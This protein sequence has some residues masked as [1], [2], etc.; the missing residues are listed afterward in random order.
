MLCDIRLLLWLRARH[1]RTALVRL[2]HFG[3]TDLVEDRSPG[4]RAY[5]LYLAAIAAVWAALMWAA[6]LDATAAAFAAVGPA[7]SA[8]ALALGLLAPVAV[9]AWAAV[10]ALRTSPVKLAHAD[11][12]FVAAGPLGM[13]A[14]AGMGCASSMLAG[15]AAGALAGCVLDVGLESGLGAFAPPVAC[16]LAAALLVA[17]AVGGAWLLGAAR[18]AC[19]R[20]IRRRGTVALALA[21]VAAVL[22]VAALAL[23]VPPAAFAPGAPG[24]AVACAAGIAACAAEGGLLA[25][26]AP[27]IDRTAVIVENALY[28]D[29]QPFGP[30]SPLDPQAVAD[31]RR[32]RKLAARLAR[33]VRFR[34]PLASGAGALVSR[35]ALSHL[36]Q[37]GGLPSLLA[38]GA[39]AAPLGVLALAGAGGP[40]TFLFW[41]AALVMF[42]QGAREA[43]RAFRDDLRVRLVRDRLPF[44]TLSLL[45]LDS[46]P[47]LA[48]SRAVSC[49]VV[50]LVL[51]AGF[52]LAAGLVLAVLVN[53][54]AVL[55][56]GLDAVRLFPGG[57]QPF[58]EAGALVLVA[59]TGALSLA[60]SPSLTVA[61]AAAVCA[62]VAA[63]VRGGAERAR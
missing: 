7:S 28:A 55:C 16:A 14:I 59:A 27:R 6:L 45:A 35:A 22:G 62:A 21:A 56:C 58:Y 24:M 4:E 52:P 53:A 20:A 23:G 33:G 42:P 13:R 3:G 15:A 1:A 8:M 57:P 31:Y 32:R 39:S 30:F 34:L 60:G 36:R 61:G 54:A 44:G 40:V 25:L 38:F 50:A 37:Y 19:P 9:F 18:L 46:L 10:R 11:M 29:L 26:L 12:P 49:A 17:A 43:T 48:V 41:L 47:G 2:V 63:V 51:P 5:Q